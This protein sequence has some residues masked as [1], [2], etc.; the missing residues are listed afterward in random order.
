MAFPHSVTD[1]ALE[2]SNAL[3]VEGKLRLS[4]ANKTEAMSGTTN[5]LPC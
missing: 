1:R 4:K 2:I 5:A 3:S